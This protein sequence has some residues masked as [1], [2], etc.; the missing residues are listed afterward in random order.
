M[1]FLGEFGGFCSEIV[2]YTEIR[3]DRAGESAI[4]NVQ[5]EF[6]FWRPN[7]KTNTLLD[8]DVVEVTLSRG[9]TMFR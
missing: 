1:E 7:V 5:G 4:W 9:L 3:V 6:H 2:D 8:V